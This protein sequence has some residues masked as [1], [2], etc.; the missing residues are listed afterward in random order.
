MQL[1]KLVDELA[2]FRWQLGAGKACP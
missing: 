2:F 1:R